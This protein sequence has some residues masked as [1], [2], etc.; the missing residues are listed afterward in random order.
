[1]SEVKN[2][3]KY[4]GELQIVITSEVTSTPYFFASQNMKF[5]SV[6]NTF[7]YGKALV[8]K[9]PASMNAQCMTNDSVTALV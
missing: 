2:N 8:F 7:A 4:R 9:H 3:P 6:N 1:M 5:S